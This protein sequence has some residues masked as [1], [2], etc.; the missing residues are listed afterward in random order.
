VAAQADLS[1][2]GPDETAANAAG[3][4]TPGQPVSGAFT[5]PSDVDYLGVAVAQ[6]GET[7]TFTIQNTTAQC[8][9]PNDAGC[10]L[11]ATLMDSS[12]QN[13]VGGS[14]S[15]AGTI[16]TAGDTESFSWTFS[17]PG[18]YELLLESNGD[19]PA[20]SPSYT[21]TLGAPAGG[22][23][24]PPG[25]GGSGSDTGPVLSAI[26]I[27]S[28]DGRQV[29]LGLDVVHEVRG[30]LVSLFEARASR[31]FSRHRLGL[32]KAGWHTVRINL[33]GVIVRRIRHRRVLPLRAEITLQPV[34]GRAF[35]V[36]RKFKLRA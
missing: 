14:D 27:H 1:G 15:D 32:L 17:A 30:G 31:P 19:L 26:R 10:P 23:G 22:G 28:R 16:A 2:G 21:V 25:P 36:V 6:A 13:Q 4:L 18:R 3:P 33:P 29:Q 8:A 24:A 20:G 7:L 9:D 34:T 12:G 5:G 11:Y 35:T